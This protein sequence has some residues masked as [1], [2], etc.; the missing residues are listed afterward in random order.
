MLPT[1]LALLAFANMGAEG[2]CAGAED[3]DDVAQD[4]I[5]SQVWLYY[6]AKIDRTDVRATYRF[7]NE[8][9][10]VLQLKAP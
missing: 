6:N 5:V 9:G 10:T 8:L 3:S 2:G 1:L 7:G 4:R